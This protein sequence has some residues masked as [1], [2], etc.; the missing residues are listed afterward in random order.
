[1][2]SAA[3]FGWRWKVI[4]GWMWR[5]VVKAIRKLSYNLPRNPSI[6]VISLSLIRVPNFTRYFWSLGITNDEL[7]SGFLKGWNYKTRK[8]QVFPES[9][10]E[11][12]RQSRSLLPD[13]IKKDGGKRDLQLKASI[14]SWQI[15]KMKICHNEVYVFYLT[16][17]VC[18]LV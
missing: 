12:V 16:E 4:T 13:H 2:F 14:F 10:Y 18:F 6:L 7:M 5:S 8:R 3:E 9:Q 17:K 15:D 1:M 11:C